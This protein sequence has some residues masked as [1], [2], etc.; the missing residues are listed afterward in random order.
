MMRVKSRPANPSL[1]CA[2]ALLLVGFLCGSSQAALARAAAAGNT[3]PSRAM[4]PARAVPSRARAARAAGTRATK[5][6]NI[7]L[8]MADDLGFEGLGCDG[9]LT[10]STPNIDR[11]AAQGMRFTNCFS[12]P[13]CTP[14]RVK[15]MTGRSNARNYVRFGYLDPT[16]PT[17]GHVLGDAGYETAIAGKWQLGLRM[18]RLADTGFERHCIWDPEV[19]LTRYWASAQLRDG[20]RVVDPDPQRFG[21]DA[22]SDFV[23]DFLSEPRERPFFLYYP[24]ILPHAPFVVTP[25]TP[26]ELGPVSERESSLRHGDEAHFVGMV[27]YLD[28]LVGRVLT[29]LEQLGIADDTLVIF[30]GDNGS[31]TQVDSQLRLASGETLTIQGGKGLLTDNGNH[32]PLVCRW[33]GLVAAGETCDSLIDFA[34]IFATLLECAELE[35]AGLE[36]DGVSFLPCLMDASTRSR[37]WIVQDYNSNPDW[38]VGEREQT[39]TVA[40]RLGRFA[41]DYDFKLYHTGW[42]YSTDDL[43][44]CAPLE[45][46]QSAF[47]DQARIELQAALAT[48]PP[49]DYALAAR[50]SNWLAF[51]R[52]DHIRLRAERRRED[53]QGRKH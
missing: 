5:A 48:L 17:F 6:P 26:G 42:L 24:M 27:A 38:V 8:I 53:A 1:L 32:V 31:P 22:I 16:Q 11:L 28:K 44:E 29:R 25:D 47:A 43:E 4:A 51:E 18:G 50:R 37:R 10:Y 52:D 30:T 49:I 41:R 14:S 36:L 34:D 2:A 21:P 20:E 40:K 35:P 12:Q 23:L 3:L 7:V 39:L 13:L 15:L 19:N 33:P 9:S 46:G 45:P